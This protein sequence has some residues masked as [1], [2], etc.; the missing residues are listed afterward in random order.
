MPLFALGLNFAWEIIYS[1]DSLL[2]NPASVQGVVNLIWAALD[3]VI[4]QNA[5]MSIMFLTMLF[6]RGST[7]GQT[8]LMAAAKWISTLSPAILGGFIEE[9]N[10]YIVL[11]GAVCFV[12]DLIYVVILHKWK[13][14]G[15]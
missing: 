8:V 12:F 9:F 3:A 11:T 10:I 15:L 2:L 5:A 7:R 4:A 13:K 14:A 6:S 1:V